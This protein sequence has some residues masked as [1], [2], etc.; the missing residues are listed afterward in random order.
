[1]R[2]RCATR[3]PALTRTRPIGV[4]VQITPQEQGVYYEEWG[5]ETFQ[6][7]LGYWT[8]DIIDPDELVAFAVLPDS[9]NAFHTGWSNAE[10]VELAQQGARELDPERRREIDR[11]R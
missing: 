4:D 5:N 11:R 7:W 9:S 2:R 8:N 3:L 10:A 1:M 6:A